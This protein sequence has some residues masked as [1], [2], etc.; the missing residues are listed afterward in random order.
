MCTV[1]SLI[2]TERYLA[3]C[4]PLTAY[5]IGRRRLRSAVIVIVVASVAF[6]APRFFEFR[7]TAVP[8]YSRSALPPPSPDAVNYSSKSTSISPAP[9]TGVTMIV[10]GDTWLRYDEVYQFVYNTAIYACGMSDAVV[11]LCCQSLYRV[12]SVTSS[13]CSL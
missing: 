13:S 11:G 3:V 7:P 6:N 4:A 5:R 1:P 12:V 8:L 9:M 10:L 2:S